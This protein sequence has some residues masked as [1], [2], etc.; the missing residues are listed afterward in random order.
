[1]ESEPFMVLEPFFLF[2][3]KNKSPTQIGETTENFST[4][5]TSVVSTNAI[6]NYSSMPNL[7]HEL[8]VKIMP[9][10]KFL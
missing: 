1:M 6:E 8:P 2:V 4:L 9:T 5:A 7:T 10:K 3:Q